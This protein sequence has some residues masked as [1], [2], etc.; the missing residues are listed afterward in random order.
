MKINKKKM[1]IIKFPRENP[2]DH[3]NP[4]IQCENNKNHESHR[5]TFENI[6]NNENHVIP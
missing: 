6:E 4:R 2:A 5:I 1:K 3:E